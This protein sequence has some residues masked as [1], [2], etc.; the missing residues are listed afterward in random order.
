MPNITVPFLSNPLWKK[1]QFEFRFHFYMKKGRF[2]NVVL[3]ETAEREAERSPQQ[4]DSR[5][6]RAMLAA[7]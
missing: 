1:M 5:R 4:R 3:H 6:G 2:N 7:K